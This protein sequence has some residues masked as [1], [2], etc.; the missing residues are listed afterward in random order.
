MNKTLFALGT[1]MIGG[2]ALAATTVQAYRGDPSVQGPNYTPER[3]AAM[4]KAFETKDYN[5]WKSQM[6]GRGRVT[7]VVTA[8]NFAQFARAHELAEDGK[9]AEANA[10]RAELGLGMH[11]G[12]GSGRGYG[13]NR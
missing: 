3:H 10:I 11:N 5:A 7:Q 12:S 2:F 1:L 13:R 9:I 8:E 6:Q 4:E